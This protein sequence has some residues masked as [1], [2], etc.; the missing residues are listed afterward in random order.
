MYS[1]ALRLAVH[2]ANAWIVVK[3]MKKEMSPS[4]RCSPVLRVCIVLTQVLLDVLPLL[5]LAP[6][7]IAAAVTITVAVGTL[8]QILVGQ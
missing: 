1:P 4:P 3:I 6:I 8:N 2:M 5:V 7:A